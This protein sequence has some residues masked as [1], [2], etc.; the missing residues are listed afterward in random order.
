ME[1]ELTGQLARLPDGQL[2][3]IEIVHSDGFATVGR[4]D[5]E[6]A[7]QIAVCRLSSVKLEAVETILPKQEKSDDEH[8]RDQLRQ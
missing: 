7:G 1:T 5:G 8:S 4:I 3:K 6:W 2:V